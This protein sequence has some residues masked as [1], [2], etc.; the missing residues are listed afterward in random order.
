MQSP[1]VWFWGG[2][3][4]DTLLSKPLGIPEPGVD[5]KTHTLPREKGDSSQVGVCG[6]CQ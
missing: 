1:S 3:C 2:P 5:D 6:F 4:E